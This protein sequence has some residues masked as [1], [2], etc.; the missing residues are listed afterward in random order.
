MFIQYVYVDIL[1]PLAKAISIMLERVTTHYQTLKTWI[2]HIATRYHNFTALPHALLH[3]LPY[4]FSQFSMALG[5]LQCVTIKSMHYHR[6]YLTYF[7]RLA[8]FKAICN[9]LPCVTVKFIK[10]CI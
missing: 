8:W 9:A 6:R 2:D 10:T 3:A 7:L 5:F 4:I 1:F